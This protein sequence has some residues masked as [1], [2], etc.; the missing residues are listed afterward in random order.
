MLAR[1]LRIAAAT[2]L[3]LQCLTATAWAETRIAFVSPGRADEFFWT[4]VAKTMQAAADQFGYSLEVVHAERDAQRMIHLG[5]D[6]VNRDAPPDILVLVNEF[7]AAAEIMQAADARGIKVFMLLNSFAGSEAHEMGRP[8][9]RYRNWIGSLVPRNFDAGKRMAENLIACMRA[10]EPNRQHH[11]L[12]L[13]GDA[14]TPASIERSAGMHVVLAQQTD[15]VIDRHFRT[16]WQRPDGKRHMLNYLDWAKS[17]DMHPDGVW[18]ANDALAQGVI[19]AAKERNLAAGKDFCV[20]GLNWSPEALDLVQNG[21]MAATDGG[22]FLAGA[23]SMVMIN[24]YLQRPTESD[25]TRKPLGAATFDMALIDRQNVDRFLA[26]LG[27]RDWR[28]IPFTRF[29]A[30]DGRYDFSLARILAFISE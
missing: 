7:Q 2:F 10:L 18:A 16:N 11:M 8:G 14:R 19:D 21:T 4:E 24:D 15:I 30:V 28:R 29:T 17:H 6:Q 1:F 23:W 5:L 13:S 20:V 26:A 27:D 25:G 9:G 3:L 12:A 22:H